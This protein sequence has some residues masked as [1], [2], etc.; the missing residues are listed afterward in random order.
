MINECSIPQFQETFL[1]DIEIWTNKPK[2][3][4]KNM[5]TE[6][7]IWIEVYMHWEFCVIYGLMGFMISGYVS[8]DLYEHK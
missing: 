3:R 5:E 7:G 4:H 6:R 8:I 1:C 2:F